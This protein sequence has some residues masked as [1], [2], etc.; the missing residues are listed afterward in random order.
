MTINNILAKKIG[1]TTIFKDGES[2]HATILKSGPCTVTQIKNKKVDGY[3]AIQLGFEP[4]K[5][6][7]KPLTGHLIKTIVNL[8]HSKNSGYLTKYQ[9]RLE[10][11]LM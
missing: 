6:L 10:I 11:Q 4:A 1:S 2:K 9:A 3:S 5:N 8:E 7:N